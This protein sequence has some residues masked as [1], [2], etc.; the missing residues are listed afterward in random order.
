MKRHSFREYFQKTD[1]HLH[2]HLEDRRRTPISTI[3]ISIYLIC[4]VSFISFRSVRR[5]L[6]I[7][8][9]GHKIRLIWSPIDFV[10]IL[11]DVAV[12]VVLVVLADVVVVW[13]NVI[14]ISFTLPARAVKT[15]QE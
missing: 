5:I 8:F 7:L 6:M 14:G 3:V 2:K 1:S 12:A 13:L 10:V 15:L 4:V 11:V 9:H